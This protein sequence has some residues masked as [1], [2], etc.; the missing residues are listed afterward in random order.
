MSPDS[1]LHFPG[2]DLLCWTKMS[3]RPLYSGLCLRSMTCSFQQVAVCMQC[4]SGYMYVLCPYFIQQDLWRGHR[5]ELAVALACHKTYDIGTWTIVF[6][7]VTSFGPLVVLGKKGM[8]YIFSENCSF[9]FLMGSLDPSRSRHGQ[10]L[11]KT[12]ALLTIPKRLVPS[13]L[14]NGDR[15]W[16]SWV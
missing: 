15:Q 5:G 8:I 13:E 6:I 12:L 10:Q 2:R 16:A 9:K 11:S 1:C 14:G 7:S 3:L 4:K